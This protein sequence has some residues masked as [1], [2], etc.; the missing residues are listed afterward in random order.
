MN[1]KK[2]TLSI[3]CY[4]DAELGRVRLLKVCESIKLLQLIIGKLSKST[5]NTKGKKK[6]LKGV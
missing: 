6:I 3:Q 4:V 5:L 1:T 2:F